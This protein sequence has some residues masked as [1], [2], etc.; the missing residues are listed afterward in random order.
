MINDMTHLC[1]FVVFILNRKVN[2]YLSKAPPALLLLWCCAYQRKQ[3][4]LLKAELKLGSTC[5]MLVKSY[6]AAFQRQVPQ[7]AFG[8]H[9][10]FL[11]KSK[12]NLLSFFCLTFQKCIINDK[13]NYY[14]T[15]HAD[16]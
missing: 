10:A 3:F 14:H 4:S 15:N 1:W 8:K 7:I 13:C 5:K 2:K 16:K 11:A 9:C 12:S 6:T